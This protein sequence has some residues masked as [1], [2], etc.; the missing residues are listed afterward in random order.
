MDLVVFVVVGMLS[1]SGTRGAAASTSS[2]GMVVHYA[3]LR[4]L[5]LSVAARRPT[6]M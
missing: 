6:E 3:S 2:I 4:Q 5:D 1:G